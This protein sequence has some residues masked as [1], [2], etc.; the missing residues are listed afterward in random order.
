MVVGLCWFIKNGKMEPVVDQ[1]KI[2]LPVGAHR[3]GAQVSNWREDRS[4]EG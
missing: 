3:G 2:E 4:L 1:G